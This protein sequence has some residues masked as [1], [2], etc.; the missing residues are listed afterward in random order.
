MAIEIVGYLAIENGGSFHNYV[1][2]Y[3]RV[4]QNFY[5]APKN[6][7]HDVDEIKAHR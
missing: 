5:R 3:R 2:V 1:N 7:S 6:T 4:S